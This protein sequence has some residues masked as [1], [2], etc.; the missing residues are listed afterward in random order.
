MQHVYAN[1]TKVM[2]DSR[3]GGNLL[4]L[5]LDKLMQQAGGHPGPSADA[6]PVE[7]LA[8]PATTE[9]RDTRTRGSLVRERGDR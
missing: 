6:A 3:G 9:T 5:P 2:V 8:A 7:R 1:T 4:Y